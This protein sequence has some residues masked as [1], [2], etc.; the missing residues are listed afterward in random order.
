MDTF[1][2]NKVD[3]IGPLP[4]LGIETVNLENPFLRKSCFGGALPEHR[5]GCLVT[6]VAKYGRA[7]GKLQIG[8]V[9]LKIDGVH[10]SQ[11]G[12][13]LFRGQEWLPWE[14]LITKK[15]TGE[16][17]TVTVLRRGDSKEAELEFKIELAP[18]PKLAPLILGVDYFPS[19]VIFGGIVFL[20]VG[21]PL[22]R[23]QLNQNGGL[24]DCITKVA[25]RA[26][27]EGELAEPDQQLCVV[28]AILPH[29]INVSYEL[30]W[31]E[32]ASKVNGIDIKN[33]K[34]LAQLFSGIQEG[35]VT[36]DF[37][38]PR[39]ATQHIVFDAAKAIECNVEILAS[40]K[41]NHWCSPELL[42]PEVQFTQ[43]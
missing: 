34:H 40:N 21:L 22:G 28:T 42:S 38:V 20:P 8:D 19:Y 32:V 26:M 16:C 24:A 13:V 7:E 10:V 29:S 11:K 2:R 25:H 41:I 12:E 43:W 17:I 35:E 3:K 15:P 30:F 39:N 36:I 23:A 31:G 6:A 18:L 33:M 37:K 1:H 4:E 14:Y 9:L 27:N 5:H